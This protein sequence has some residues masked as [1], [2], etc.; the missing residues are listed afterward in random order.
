MTNSVDLKTLKAGL[1]THKFDL[2]Y[3]FHKYHSMVL[4][5]ETLERL[6][7]FHQQ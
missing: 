7:W 6:E 2:L 4:S 1:D 5:W 3:K